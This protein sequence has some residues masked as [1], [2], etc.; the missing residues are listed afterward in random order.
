[1]VAGV[2]PHRKV[3]NPLGVYGKLDGR[4]LFTR[5]D[6]STQRA[7]RTLEEGQRAMGIDWMVWDDLIEAI[8]PV[9]TEHIGTQL[10]AAIEVAA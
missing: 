5:K 10:L 7:A 9:Y 4:R 1:V 2:P 3:V 8:P 6:G